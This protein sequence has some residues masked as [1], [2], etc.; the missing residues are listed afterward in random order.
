[1]GQL[2][3][4]AF[5]G[6]GDPDQEPSGFQKRLAATIGAPDF[7]TLKARLI[8]LRMRARRAFD[9]VLPPIRDGN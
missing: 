9:A 6:G 7:D 8:D 3:A 4:C 1:L 2:M 5:D